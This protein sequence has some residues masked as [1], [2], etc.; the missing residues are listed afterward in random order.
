MRLR[1]LVEASGASIKAG[2]MTD[3]VENLEKLLAAGKK[4]QGA[5]AF[6]E[7][8]N[9]ARR[10][11]TL[12]AHEPRALNA[13]GLALTAE[14]RHE[15]AKEA[16]AAA[17]DADPSSSKYRIDLAQSL[18]IAGDLEA[19]EAALRAALDLDPRSAAALHAL[20]WIRKVG[21]NDPIIGQLEDA[22]RAAGAKDAD[23]AKCSYALGKC[24]DD[25]G[26]YDLAFQHYRDAN[27]RPSSNFDWRGV[28]S[29]F[30]AIKSV[31]TKKFAEQRREIGFPSDKPIFIVGMP[32]CGSTLLEQKMADR[33]GVASL[34]ERPEILQM[35]D[36]IARN[37][38]RHAAYPDWCPDLPAAAWE[39]FGRLYVERFEA[40]HA[41][42]QKFVDK[43]LPNFA[44]LG[45]IKTM[46]P[47]A[48]A[49]DCRRNPV[50]TCLSCYFQDLTQHPYSRSLS[51]LGRVYRLYSDLMAHWR[52]LFDIASV[53]YEDFV[54]APDEHIDRLLGA[55]RLDKPAGA[56]D[57][58]A[59]RPV[60][61]WSAVQV[62]KPVYGDSV[63]RWK[64][65]EKHLTPLLEALGD[66]APSR[67]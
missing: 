50:D 22:K 29:F 40:E 16:L 31:W 42:A 59:P 46:L 52:E 57:V 17:V 27:N 1:W 12:S 13:L 64:N 2:D 61:S 44:Y 23:Y 4:A 7:A 34:G 63:G 3:T 14:R 15:E 24:Y 35:S 25:I 43:N 49:I 41:G 47:N 56:N 32:R 6:A 67:E 38:P 9:L 20:A 48:L 54:A 36:A 53:N 55:S 39:G 21:P 45:M 62:R 58:R 26:E 28:Q 8:A 18:I 60:E 11:L 10:A 19:A 33:H 30:D 66:L 5:G 51:D 65:Y 37:H